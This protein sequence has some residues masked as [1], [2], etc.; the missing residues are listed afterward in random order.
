MEKKNRKIIEFL[1]KENS[2]LNSRLKVRSATPKKIDEQLLQTTNQL[3]SNFLNQKR[4][5]KQTKDNLDNV[6]KIQKF[7]KMVLEDNQEL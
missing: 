6:E 5:S 2:E 4:K 1:D 7:V 3:Y